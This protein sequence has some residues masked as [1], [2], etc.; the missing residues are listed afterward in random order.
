MSPTAL[1]LQHLGDGLLGSV[2]GDRRVDG[3]LL[4]DPANGRFE[5]I[6]RRDFLDDAHLEGRFG[7]ITV[8]RIHHLPRHAGANQADQRAQAFEC[9][10]DA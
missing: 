10:R 5:H 8:A 9:V 7:G 3:D 4:G 2:D 6:G 1:I